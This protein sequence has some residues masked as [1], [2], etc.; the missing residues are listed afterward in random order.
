MSAQGSRGFY[1]A[2]MALI[3]SILALSVGGV[4]YNIASAPT[5]TAPP[6]TPPVSSFDIFIH[7]GW[8]KLNISDNDYPTTFTSG[9]WLTVK[10]LGN[11]TGEVVLFFVETPD[12]F[13][14]MFTGPSSLTFEE[15]GAVENTT[16]SLVVTG[17]LTEEWLPSSFPGWTRISLIAVSA[18]VVNVK[19]FPILVVS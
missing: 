4:A 3:I 9:Q 10:S 15:P 14:V 18:I 16:F 12:N 8:A 19:S 1:I 6:V 13:K 17:S 2:V 11:F 5:P 7:P